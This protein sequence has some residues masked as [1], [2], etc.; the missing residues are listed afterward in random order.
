MNTTQTIR[1]ISRLTV[2]ITAGGFCLA[3]H[4]ADITV[5]IGQ[6]V[7]LRWPS[8]VGRAYQ[9]QVSTNLQSNWTPSGGLMEG[10]GATLGAF[11]AA[12]NVQR[13]FRIHETKASPVS[14]LDGTWTGRAYAY[15]LPPAPNEEAMVELVVNATNRTFRTTYTFSAPPDCTATLRLL[16]YSDTRAEF[17]ESTVGCSTGPIVLTRLNSTTIAFNFY[18]SDPTF[19]GTGAGLLTKVDD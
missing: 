13:F 9:I 11:I 16:S 18:Y 3:A 12:T 8:V 15:N 4:A 19:P 2:A 17:Q 5:S 7:Q 6:A 14:W 1:W 10:S